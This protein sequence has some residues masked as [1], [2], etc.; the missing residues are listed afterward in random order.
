MKFR[1]S[2]PISYGKLKVGQIRLANYYED[3]YPRGWCLFKSKVKI[4]EIR[5][6]SVL[7]QILD[8]KSSCYK[9]QNTFPD[10]VII[11]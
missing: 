11:R 1:G 4:I 8:P 2:Q 9:R 6:L 3:L 7:I 5:P 10:R